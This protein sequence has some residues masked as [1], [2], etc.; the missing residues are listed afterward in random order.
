MNTVAINNNMLNGLFDNQQ[1]LDELF[2]SI[3]DDDNYSIDSSSSTFQAESRHSASDV[4]SQFSYGDDNIN[5]SPLAIIHNP[6]CYILLIM[7]EAAVIYLGVA[8]LL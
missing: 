3:F 1:K 8:N 2:D 7:I 6:F 5:K 4:A